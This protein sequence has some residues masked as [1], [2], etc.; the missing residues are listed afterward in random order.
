MA[1]PAKNSRDRAW[2]F[3]INNPTPDDDPQT[4]LGDVQGVEYAIWALEQG[5][6]EETIHWQGYVRFKQPKRLAAMKKLF[7]RAHLETANGTDEDNE[8]YCSKAPL[9]GPFVIGKP[10]R[11]GSRNDWLQIKE[12]CKR[13][14]TD[15]DIAELYPGH[16]AR[17]YGGIQRLKSV[18]TQPR[19]EKPT[20][21]VI[22]GRPGFGKTYYAK[23]N[24]MPNP[25]YEKEPNTKWWDG[26]DGE[27]S[28]LLDEFKGQ[29]TFTDI[30]RF[31]DAY[32]YKAEVKGGIV[33]IPAKFVA[34]TTNYMPHTWYDFQKHPFEALSRRV[35]FW[36][37]F[38]GFKQYSVFTDYEEFKLKEYEYE[39]S[40]SY[41]EQ[42]EEGSSQNPVQVE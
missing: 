22:Y 11:Q 15:Q 20:V 42:F 34:I 37:L 18:F 17:N 14:A 35:D 36:I 27:E 21:W 41:Q 8:T 19:T 16:F 30:K 23:H 39:S 4:V 40:R 26:Y 3:T 6:E 2:C 5:S 12:L 28:I 7:P 9:E 13:K 1:D 33:R 24:L 32:D 10:R 25:V 29:M 31:L 38:T